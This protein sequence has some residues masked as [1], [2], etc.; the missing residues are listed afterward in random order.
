MGWKS[1]P[2]REIA[3]QLT[4]LQSELFCDIPQTEFIVWNQTTKCSTPKLRLSLK[5][6][7]SLIELFCHLF[8]FSVSII[9]LSHMTYFICSVS[10]HFPSFILSQNSYTKFQ[11]SYSSIQC[12]FEM[13]IS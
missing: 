11:S 10:L 12:H 5:F 8:H 6:D 9:L 2:S 1:L 4:I 7:S 3:E 13:G